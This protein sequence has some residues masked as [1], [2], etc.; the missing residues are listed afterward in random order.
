MCILTICSIQRRDRLPAAESLYAAVHS[1]RWLCW[2]ISDNLT[3]SYVGKTVRAYR[4]TSGAGQEDYIAG[5][6][7]GQTHEGARV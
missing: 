6:G 1:A 5:E 4:K 3:T 7:C 2:L